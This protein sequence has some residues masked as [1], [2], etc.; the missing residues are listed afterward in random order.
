M[1]LTKHYKLHNVILPVMKDIKA[2]IGETIIVSSIKSTR[3]DQ[4]NIEEFVKCCTPFYTDTELLIKGLQDEITTL[5]EKLSTKPKRKEYRRLSANDKAD[6]DKCIADGL[7]NPA[8][9]KKFAVS[10]SMVSR[11][12]PKKTDTNNEAASDY[13]Q[14]LGD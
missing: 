5:K 11:R 14:G 1:E 4:I 2:Q 8:I 6:V 13:A 10:E 7:S 9:A 12:R 3:G